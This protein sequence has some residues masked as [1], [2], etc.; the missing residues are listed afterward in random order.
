MM[1]EIGAEVIKVELAP[2]GDGAR[3]K[4][5]EPTPEAE[6]EWVELVTRPTALTAYQNACTPGYYNG[7]G[8][9][10]MGFFQAQY[11]DGGPTFSECSPAGA[12][13]GISRVS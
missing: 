12:S 10:V 5:R 11:P 13:R 2:A 6:A 7:E 1:A 9:N 3:S 8:Q 4:V